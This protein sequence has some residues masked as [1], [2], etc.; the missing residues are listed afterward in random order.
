MPREKTVSKKAKFRYSVLV[1]WENQNLKKKTRNFEQGPFGLLQHPFCWKTSKKRKGESHSAEKLGSLKK[2]VS[3]HKEPTKILPFHYKWKSRQTRSFD[4]RFDPNKL[5][6]CQVLETAKVHWN[7]QDLRIA[8]Q[9]R[10]SRLLIF[11]F[12]KKLWCGHPSVKNEGVF[13]TLSVENFKCEGEKNF[14]RI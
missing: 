9:L 3:F 14:E 10:G 6:R 7:C 8:S 12:V 2:R 5:E 11:N 13:Q 1:H 4:L